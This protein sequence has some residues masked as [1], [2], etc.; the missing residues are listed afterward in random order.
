M[1]LL[2]PGQGAFYHV[3]LQAGFDGNRSC[4]D[5][6]ASAHGKVFVC[7]Q[8]QIKKL[9]F[10]RERIRHSCARPEICVY[11]EMLSQ[12]DY[13]LLP[14]APG[15]SL[16]QKDLLGKPFP[17][18]SISFPPALADHLN[19]HGAHIQHPVIDSGVLHGGGVFQLLK[20]QVRGHDHG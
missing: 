19:G 18:L 12:S 3:S 15:P 2:K 4:A 20:R 13:S 10:R 14:F 7:A 6:A 8:E 11:R 9:L 1:P 16:L 5:L 17:P